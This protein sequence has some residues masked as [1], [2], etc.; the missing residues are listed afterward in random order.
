MKQIIVKPVEQIEIVF[1]DDKRYTVLFNMDAVRYFQEELNKRDQD[2]SELTVTETCGMILYGGIRANG[3]DIAM[4]EALALAKMLD[5]MSVNGIIE[6][7]NNQLYGGLDAEQKEFQKKLTAQYLK[8]K[9]FFK[10]IVRR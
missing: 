3:Q 6:D 9:G 10:K 5:I 4:Q 8:K 1:S 7:F 2:Y